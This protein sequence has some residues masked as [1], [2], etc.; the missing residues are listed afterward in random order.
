LVGSRPGNAR[1]PGAGWTDIAVSAALGFAVAA[2]VLTMPWHVGPG[3]EAYY[4]YHAVRMLGGEVLYRDVSELITP[5]YIDLMAILFRVFGATMATARTV[6]SALQAAIVVVVYL[7]CRTL[8]VQRGLSVAAALGEMAVAYP[9]WPYATPH[10]VGTLLVSVLLL[11]ALDRRPGR[12]L[13]RALVDGVLVGLLLANR[14]PTGIVMAV[15]VSVLVLTDWLADRRW[16]TVGGPSVVRRLGA[17]AMAASLVF[18][19]LLGVHALAAGVEPLFRQLV[20]HPLTGYREVN[21]VSWGQ[22]DFLATDVAQHLHLVLFRWLPLAMIAVTA[23][24][25]AVA[26]TRG[27]DRR[28]AERQGTLLVIAVFSVLSILYNP[29]YVHLAFIMPVV[30]VLAADGVQACLDATGRYGAVIGLALAGELIAASGIE[31]RQN[32]V[33]ARGDFP[34]SR[35]TAFGRVDLT[36]GEAAVVERMRRL[37]NVT[38]NRELFIYPG[39]PALAL[40][41]GARNPTRH[42][43]I[44]PKYQSDEEMRGVMQAIARRRPRYV[45]LMWYVPAR[46]PIRT[47]VE[48][49][50]RCKRG[51][52]LCVL[53]RRASGR[54]KQ[55]AAP[56]ASL[57][58]PRA[59]RYSL[60]GCPAPPASLAFTRSCSCRSASRSG[61]TTRSRGSSSSPTI[62]ST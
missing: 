45:L 1:A 61:S 6:G 5:L 17:V 4:F 39:W 31:L 48:R 19:P 30:V 46:D 35:E 41:T 58:A 56:R 55:R 47:Y 40:L 21:R 54:R 49:Y 32:L 12:R 16:G 62:S 33:R 18:V 51:R 27:R 10:W 7:T 25:A 36:Y 3:D 38:Q 57:D 8:G 43:L 29:D 11:R 13:D 34:I 2:Y 28:L 44:F 52:M 50:Y 59:M 26:W 15:A 9:A 24:R 22:V 23:A 14:H 20:V 42:D 53:D 60:D 37:L